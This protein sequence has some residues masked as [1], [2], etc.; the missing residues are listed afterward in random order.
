MHLAVQSIFNSG[1]F[2]DKF[3]YVLRKEADCPRPHLIVSHLSGF[4][5]ENRITLESWVMRYST[6]STTDMNCTMNYFIQPNN[7]NFELPSTGNMDDSTM[8]SHLSFE[9]RKEIGSWHNHGIK[10]HENGSSIRGN[11]EAAILPGSDIDNNGMFI[12]DAAKFFP[13]EGGM[14][15]L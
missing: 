14:T 13:G 7:I 12:Q 10:R 3:C 11:R 2:I 8:A 9:Q 4:P 1:Q 6:F 15:I 5:V